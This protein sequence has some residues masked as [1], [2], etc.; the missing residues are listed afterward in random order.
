MVDYVVI[1]KDVTKEYVR[2]NEV[3]KALKRINL[4]LRKGGFYAL[5][6]PSGSGK[7][8]LLNI[9]AG[10]DRPTSGVVVVDGVRVD[11]LSEDKLSRF[12][13]RIGFV[14]Q[15]FN[16]LPTLTALE[17]VEMPLELAG[18]KGDEAKRR[19]LRALSEVGLADKA[20]RF[21]YELSGGEQQ[22][23]AIARAL[24]NEPILVLADEPTGNLN[25][26]TGSSVIKL[27]KRIN[28]VKGVTFFIATHDVRVAKEA[29]KVYYLLD[30]ILKEENH[31]SAI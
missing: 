6:G 27:M 23:V 8:T 11:S 29:D 9:I 16:L 2:G 13:R 14:F 24:V 20:E 25:G 19:A 5:M 28:K 22:R 10:I 15:E 26:K 30:G 3:V 21:P 1:L 7:T 17:N 31:G 18:V 4:R 12:R